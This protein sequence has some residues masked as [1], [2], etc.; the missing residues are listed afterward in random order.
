M[1]VLHGRR[2]TFVPFPQHIQLFIPTTFNGIMDT[3]YIHPD[4]YL[5]TVQHSMCITTYRL[6]HRVYVI[7]IT[8]Y[9]LILRFY[10]GYT[11]G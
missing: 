2:F 9:R 6:K 7:C 11:L 3:C 4:L 5:S 10:V 8:I 1:F